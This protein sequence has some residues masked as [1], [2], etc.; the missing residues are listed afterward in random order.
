MVAKPP[1]CKRIEGETSEYMAQ[2]LA[3][4]RTSTLHAEIRSRI[5]SLVR[6]QPL[7][8]EFAHER[9]RERGRRAALASA[10]SAVNK[11][12]A[13]G[14]SLVSVPLTITYLD[15]E[16]YGVWL[17]LSSALAFL[18]FA[19]LGMGN[20]LL[21]ETAHALGRQ[22][23]NEIKIAIASSFFTLTTL[24][25]LL[26]LA[27]PLLMPQIPLAKIFGT[28]TLPADRE[29]YPAAAA[30]V[31]CFALNLPLDVVQRVQTGLQLA[32]YSNLWRC[33]GSVIGLLAL[34]SSVHMRLG[35]PALILSVFGSPVLSTA[36]NFVFFFVKERPDLRPRLSRYQP[37][38]AW[39]MFQQGLQFLVAQMGA[40]ILTAAP[41][42]LVARVAGAA[43]AAVVGVTQRMFL[44]PYSLCEFLWNPLWP[45]YGEAWARRDYDFIRRTFLKTTGII[46]VGMLLMVG[47][48]TYWSTQIL[49][50]WTRGAV[51]APT[52]V[53]VA[54]GVL[55]FVRVFR[56]I[57][58]A[59]LNGCGRL[60]L[61]A[62]L[63][64]AAA[65]GTLIL[66]AVLQPKTSAALLVYFV[67]G[68]EL[69]VVIGMLTDVRHLII[70]ASEGR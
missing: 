52:A 14:T 9:A 50:F 63:L 16:R 62:L 70:G 19:D 30:L 42:L 13:L 1:T 37:R 68:L 65:A 61:S 33:L 47:G 44:V 3:K 22:D 60:V 38:V 32:F 15:S 21:N 12:I 35:L 26:L 66:P 6:I 48:G 40:A 57:L 67:V 27:I 7:D 43:E 49:R 17:A 5:V 69:T 54:V 2:I 51:T 59:P 24:A 18:A 25:L 29:L 10:S 58:S 46:V 45:A 55:M 23:E 11:S 20:G 31:L 56:G 39:R 34:L 28:K 8:S 4:Q 41:L 36:A 53:V 64:A